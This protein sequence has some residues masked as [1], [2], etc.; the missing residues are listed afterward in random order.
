MWLNILVA[1]V[2]LTAAFVTVRGR[3]ALKE[4]AKRAADYPLATYGR[5]FIAGAIDATPLFAAVLFV[6]MQSDFTGY[7]M[8]KIVAAVQYPFGVATLVYLVYTTASELIAGATVGKLV[9]GLKVIRLD[10]KAPRVGATLLR[11]LLRL[12][13]VSILFPLAMALVLFTPLRQR[14]GDLAAGTVVVFKD[15]KKRDPADED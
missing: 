11:N 7:P 1:G 6:S 10:G 3:G 4:A 14:V 13:D 5:R 12:I 2:V 9:M 8:D 15:G